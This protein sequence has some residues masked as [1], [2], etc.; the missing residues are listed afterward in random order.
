MMIKHTDYY[1]SNI[2]NKSLKEEIYFYY[3]YYGNLEKVK[4]IY[5]KVNFNFPHEVCLIISLLVGEHEIINF[6]FE[7]F[8]ERFKKSIK[9]CDLKKLNIKDTEIEFLEKKLK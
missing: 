5:D 1:I 4:E 8:E 7:K 9:I 6:L 2:T 3:C